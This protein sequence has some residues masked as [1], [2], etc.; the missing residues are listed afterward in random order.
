MLSLAE[1][2]VE[3][4]RCRFDSP[5]VTCRGSIFPFIPNSSR[6]LFTPAVGQ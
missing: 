5:R 2:D 6:V 3:E 1:E 4:I